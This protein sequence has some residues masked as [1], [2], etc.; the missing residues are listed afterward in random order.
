[1]KLQ[2]R[3]TKKIKHLDSLLIHGRVGDFMSKPPM[4][5]EKDETLDEAKVLMR[6]HRISGVPIVAKEKSFSDWS[7]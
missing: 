5:M 4:T 1:M 2:R 6:K 3:K 7:P